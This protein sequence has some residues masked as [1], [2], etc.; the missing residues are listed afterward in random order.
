MGQMIDPERIFRQFPQELPED[1]TDRLS[2]RPLMEYA[3]YQRVSSNRKRYFF[4]CCGAVLHLTRG[5]EEDIYSP[6]DLLR[7]KHNETVECPFCGKAVQQKCMG[8]MRGNSYGEY[9]SLFEKRNLAVLSSFEGGLMVR[10]GTCYVDWIAGSTGFIGYPG[11]DES[12]PWPKCRMDFCE[13]RRYYI[14]KGVVLGWTKRTEYG[15]GSCREVWKKSRSVRSGFPFPRDSQMNKDAEDG[16][17]SMIGTEH[18]A[19]TELRYSGIEHY[20]KDFQEGEWS[21][22]T[23]AYLIEY[24][25]HPQLEMLSKLG[26]R[27]VVNNAMYGNRN[28]GLLNWDAENPADFFRMSKQDFKAFQRAGGT[29]SD[30]EKLLAMQDSRLTVHNFFRE[31]ERFISFRPFLDMDYELCIKMAELCGV[32]LHKAVTYALQCKNVRMW[33]DYF[34]MAEKAG[35]DLSRSEVSMPKNLRERHDAVLRLTNTKRNEALMKKYTKDILPRLKQVYEFHMD[36][37]SILV[38]ESDADIILEGKCLRHCVGGYA[39]RHLRGV[40]SILFL[41]AAEA[42]ETSLVTIEMNGTKLVQIHG[43]RNEYGGAPSPRVVYAGIVEPWLD[44]VERG[45][46]RNLAGDPILKTEKR[47]KSA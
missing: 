20:F 11:K 38:P 14:R 29:L 45:S 33:K 16:R 32:T 9:P 26:F 46:P 24:A 18:L 23:I 3:F 8:R 31:K 35:Y 7:F 28:N 37:M 13:R 41:R 5:V 42:P 4:S 17:Y 2:G 6:Y 43:Y 1:F 22:E 47:R 19:E 39:E 27:D 36:G 44:W 40:T 21:Y 30:L 15:E 25:R 10:A 12:D 34:D